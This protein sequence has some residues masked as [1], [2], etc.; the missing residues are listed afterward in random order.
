MIEFDNIKQIED[1]R[2]KMSKKGIRITI[3]YFRGKR[4]FC[5]TILLIE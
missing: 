5:V 1:K 3:R 4:L 2:H